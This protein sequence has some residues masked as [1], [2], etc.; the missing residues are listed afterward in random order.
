L[1]GRRVRGAFPT[2]RSA[3][4]PVTRE[5]YSWDVISFGFWFGDETFPKPAFY[6]Y[7]TPE[8]SGLADGPLQPPAA[9]WIERSNSH[10]ATLRYAEV[11]ILPDP[12]VAVLDFYE[13]A[14]QAGA[15]RAGL[16]IAHWVSPDGI[17]DS[18]LIVER[19]VR[20][21]HL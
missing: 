9:R 5:A 6:S 1:P 4:D 14:Y 10:L 20:S 13:G 8:P 16:D 18:R 7:T 17:T 11:R 15:R 21:V 12:R 2:C 19:E 3:T